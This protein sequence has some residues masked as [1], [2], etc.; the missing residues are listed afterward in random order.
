VFAGVIQGFLLSL[1]VLLFAEHRT[2]ASAYLGIL[3]LFITL[4]ILQECIWEGDFVNGLQY[5]LIYLPYPFAA[6]ALLYFFVETFLYPNRQHTQTEKLLFLPFYVILFISLIAKLCYLF[7]DDKH[8]LVDIVNT[9]M[10]AIDRYGDLLSIVMFIIVLILLRRSILKY[11]NDPMNNFHRIVKSKLLWL[12]TLLVLQFAFILFWIY[13]AVNVAFVGHYN[14]APDLLLVFTSVLIYIMGYIGT[15][16]IKV[17]EQRIKIREVVNKDK[18]LVIEDATVSEQLLSFEKLVK[19]K[20]LYLNS[21]LN[22]Q[23]VASQ[24]NVSKGHI[25]RTINSEL[26]I[27]F[28]DYINNLR[29]EEAK[30]YLSNSDFE[31]YTL[32]AIGLEAGFNSK[33]TFYSTFKKI[34]GQTPLQYKSNYK[35]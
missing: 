34:T 5:Y 14:Y 10:N 27:G 35:N 4:T 2:R 33:S 16:K 24:L 28:S 23:S 26:G 31:N 32:A 7:L 9:C 18:T 11:E 12:K 19:E 8:P 17:Q 20:R 6:A 21:N 15:R 30:S 1:F 13:A 29:V 3:I 25:S 22:L